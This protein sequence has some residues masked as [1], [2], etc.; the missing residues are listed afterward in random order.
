MSMK[1]TAQEIYKRLIAELPLFWD[2]RTC[3]EYMKD[4]G[5]KHWR[6]MEWPGF[7]FQFMCERI[8]GKQ[9]FMIIP[10][11]SFGNVE[12]DGFHLIPW[13]FK[14]HSIGSGSKVPTN[15]FDEIEQ[16]IAQYGNVGFIIASGDSTFDD[17]ERTFKKWHDDFKGEPSAYVQKN[18]AKGVSSR[19]RKVSFALR[20]IEIVFLDA[21]TLPLCE[22]FQEGFRN[23]NGQP[24]NPKVV[25]DL[26][27]S[28]LEHYVFKV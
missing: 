8:L 5:S 21:S 6:Q 20:Q 2:G 1:K 13:D 19:R 17:E 14:A 28:G 12:F 16:A 18:I 25:L 9:Q 27:I 15:G 11:P 23:A 26:S 3:I 22:S 7:Y 10:G 24:R 4:H